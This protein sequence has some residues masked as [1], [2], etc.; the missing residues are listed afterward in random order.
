MCSRCLLKYSSCNSSC[1]TDVQTDYKQWVR[2]IIEWKESWEDPEQVAAEIMSDLP[3]RSSFDI[4]PKLPMALSSQIFNTFKWRGTAPWNTKL[5]QGALNTVLCTV[6]DCHAEISA[7][8]PGH[9]WN[10]PQ[11][12]GGC[13]LW[14]SNRSFPQAQAQLPLGNQNVFFFLSFFSFIF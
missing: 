5:V 3:A 12:A 11:V 8:S 4:G 13:W 1:L 7:C 14:L 10:S 2:P 6:Q 9:L